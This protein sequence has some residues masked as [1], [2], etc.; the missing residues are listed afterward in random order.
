[1]GCPM[2]DPSRDFFNRI[3]EQGFDARL[4]RARGTLRFDVDDGGRVEH[5]LVSLD[6]GAIHASRGADA[7]ADCVVRLDRAAL[8]GVVSGNVNPT[9]GLLRGAIAATG[10]IDLLLYLQRLFPARQDAQDRN[11]T[12]LAGRHDG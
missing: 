6:R 2:S 12:A 5:W 3:N 4:G 11:R 10:N 9:A 1:V 8:D 7:A